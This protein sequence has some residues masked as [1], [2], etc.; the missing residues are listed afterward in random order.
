MTFITS[1]R[2]G[3]SGEKSIFRRTPKALAIVEDTAVLYFMAPKSEASTESTA[4]YPEKRGRTATIAEISVRPLCLAK[5]I[6]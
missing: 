6:Q 2:A 3:L 4:A 5:L 1:E